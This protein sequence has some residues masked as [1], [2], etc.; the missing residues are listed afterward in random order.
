MKLPAARANLLSVIVLPIGV[1]AAFQADVTPASDVGTPV[2]LEAA[3][4]VSFSNDVLPIL[5]ARCQSCHG[6]VDPATGQP[7]VEV[8]LNMTT[9]EGVMAGSEYGAVVE[10]GGPD[11]SL[12]IE[13]VMSGDMPL[14]GDP[15]P[16][17]EIE[18]LRNWI[19]EGAANN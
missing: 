10:P 17:A 16:P 12:M 2:A 18:V 5:Q 9:Y 13:M 15:V 14:E 7:S 19:A 4:G 11:A 8:G 6:G 1:A 3:Q